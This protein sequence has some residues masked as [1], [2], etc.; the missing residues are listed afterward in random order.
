MTI[1]VRIDEALE[2]K[3]RS[4]IEREGVGL[5]DFVRQAISEK[6][7]R[8]GGAKLT[9]YEAFLRIDLGPGSGQPDRSRRSEDILR[10]KFRSKRDAR[11]RDR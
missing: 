4:R 10:E 3:L 2:E 8:E 5:S 9:P 1:T 6:L 7:E 11:D